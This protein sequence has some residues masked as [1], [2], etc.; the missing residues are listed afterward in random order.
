MSSDAFRYR[1]VGVEGRDVVLEIRPTTAGGLCDLMWT[2][3]FVLMLLREQQGPVE[4][5][6]TMN[7]PWL[8]A[9]LDEFIER[10]VPEALVGYATE[11]TL[12][13]VCREY[14]IPAEHLQPRLRVRATM[15]SEALAAHFSVGSSDGTTAFDVWWQD[16]RHVA[17]LPQA[18]DAPE[19]DP[20]VDFERCACM[21]IAARSQ[22][23]TLEHDRLVC[24]GVDARLV[25]R[26]TDSYCKIGRANF[27]VELALE[28][29]AFEQLP[30]TPKARGS[31]VDLVLGQLHDACATHRFWHRR[32]ANEPEVARVEYFADDA[33]Q[34]SFETFVERLA[35][36]IEPP[37]LDAMLHRDGLRGLVERGIAS[38]PTKKGQTA[39][40]PLGSWAAPSLP[41]TFHWTWKLGKHQ[42]WRTEPLWNRVALHAAF[43]SKDEARSALAQARALS[44]K[45]P[46]IWKGLYA[47]LD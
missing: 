29:P 27:E 41:P 25:V 32:F 24:E 4:F 11:S 21:A 47:S 22:R 9:H 7:V 16:P 13:D 46:A 5:E 23:W 14:C 26:P 19:F 45:P 35:L 30:A 31:R 20:Q 44:G 38:D 17:K 12:R 15:T 42:R 10:V 43:G 40:V 3:S 18:E 1:V 2:R 36:A 34:E 8:T 39:P 37:E 28:V 6:Q 33:P